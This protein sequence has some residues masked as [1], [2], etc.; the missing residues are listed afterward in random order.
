MLEQRLLVGA[1]FVDQDYVF[2][3][4]DG[5]PLHPERVYQAFKRRVRKRQ[6]PYLLPH[7]LRH[8]WATRIA[9]ANASHVGR[10]VARATTCAEMQNLEWSSTP[11][12]ILASLPST[13]LT[14][15]TMS[16]CHNSIARARSH[17]TYSDRFRFLACGVTRR[18][19]TSHR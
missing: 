12:T 13:I 18:W 5:R 9:I 7:G 17:R 4:P 2:C 3:E 15:P 6:V 1:G 11:D 14:P 16:I 19:R 10:A 8:T